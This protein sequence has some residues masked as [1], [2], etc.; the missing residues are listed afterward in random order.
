MRKFIIITSLLL[1]AVNLVSAQNSTNS[2][3]EANYQKNYIYINPIQ[4]VF[5]TLQMG[6][7]RVFKE[8]KRSII[9]CLGIYREEYDFIKNKGFTDELQYRFYINSNESD[10]RNKLTFDY[11]LGPYFN[12]KFFDINRSRY[13]AHNFILGAVGGLR[14]SYKSFALD[15]HVGGGYKHVIFG[16]YHTNYNGYE[17]F[18]DIGYTG[19]LPK[20]GVQIGYKF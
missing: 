1:L 9:I 12:H 2:E 18:S 17:E 16:G 20:L 15:L 7:E 10:D 5:Y 11:Y 6:Y 8:N 3:Y 14:L 19:I 4:P 13:T